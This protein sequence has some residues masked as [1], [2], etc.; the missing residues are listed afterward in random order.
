HDVEFLRRLTAKL[1]LAD[2]SIPDLAAWELAGCVVFVPFG[3]GSVLAWPSRFAPLCLP[4]FHLYDR[5]IEPETAVR[6]AA[7]DRINARDDCR[8]LLLSKRALENYL[9][10]AAIVNAGGGMVVVNDTDSIALAVAR[11]WYQRQPQTLPWDEL[12][13]RARRRLAARCKRWLNTQAVNAMTLGMLR[14]RDPAGEL[15][16]WLREIAVAVGDRSGS[17]IT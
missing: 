9:H 14:Q 8:A 17:S 6:Q 3:G 16:S 12:T 2:A 5:E 15:I 1:H 7:V 13:P 4:E 10:T 11:D